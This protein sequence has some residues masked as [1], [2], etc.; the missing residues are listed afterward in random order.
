[1]Q[2]SGEN[3]LNE[4]IEKIRKFREERDWDQYHSPKN[5]TKALMVEVGELVE[6]FQWLTQEQSSTLPPD[7]LAEVKEEIGDVL[8]YLVN[9]C[10]KLGI[11]PMQAAFDKLE[12]NEE[13]Y[14]APMVKGKSLK[15][16]E[17]K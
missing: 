13:K 16:S 5:L 11:D 10:D 3:S 1:M 17:Y 8:I 12:K 15:Y 4:L 9:L 2:L 14:P 6:Q 7:K